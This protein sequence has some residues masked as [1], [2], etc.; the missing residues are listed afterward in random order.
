MCVEVYKAVIKM[1]PKTKKNSQRIVMNRKTGRPFLLQS[2]EYTQYEKDCRYFLKIPD[3]PIDYPINIKYTF[4]RKNNIRC[5]LSNLIACCDDVLVKYG[6]LVDDNFHIIVGHD[7]SRVK[8]D[9]EN[10]R[11]EIII[12]KEGEDT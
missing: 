8:I 4:Y 12:Y 10:P 2:E 5:D 9:K 3:K 1:N 11:T 6:I 7:G